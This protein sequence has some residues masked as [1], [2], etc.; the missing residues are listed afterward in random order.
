[1]SSPTFESLRH[2][3]A[4]IRRRRSRLHIA[5][6]SSIA[7][8]GLILLIFS[9]SLIDAWLLPS[10]TGA[11]GLFLVLLVG[12]AALLWRFIYVL[13][14]VQSD[15][16]QLAHYV[17]EKIPD[18]EQRLLTSLE[19]SQEE[20]EFGRKGVS[21]QFIK[22]LW[23]DAE[24][25]V[26]QQHEQVEHL[27]SSPAPW[28]AM[29]TA[30]AALA[31]VGALFLSSD[32]LMR[33]G[34][35]LLWP[36]KP[37]P[38]PIA[39]A[40][41]EEPLEIVITVEPG[42]ISMQRGDAATI[43][44]RVLNAAP[45]DVQLRMQTDSVNWQDA[46]MGQDGSGSD[47]ASYSYFLPSVQQDTV[48]YVNFNHLG[49]Q[50]SQQFRIN[51]YDLPKVEQINVAY[52][53]PEYTGWNNERADNSGDM[54]VPEGTKVELEV[55]FNKN[56]A[57]AE[58]EFQN[59][60][61]AY[62]NIELLVDGAAG[63]VA[64]TV[65]ADTAY[66]INAVDFDRL[67][68]RD[69]QDYYIRAIED[70]PP[71]LVLRSPG[72]DQDV[73]P[74][75]EVVLEVE[76][77]DDYGISRFSLHYSVVGADE[78]AVDFLPEK[79]TRTIVGNELI[80]LEDLQ[81]APGD[82]V[83]YYLTLADNN[84]LQGAAEVIS[85]IYFLQIIPT[86]QEFRQVNSGGQGQGRQ[87]G[88]RGD[89]SELVTVQKD[90][91]AATWKLRQQI[92][93][94]ADSF[95]EDVAVVAEA[96]LEATQRAQM[97][98][99][100]LSERLSFS[101]ASYDSA[102]RN[103]QQAIEQMNLAVQELS[104]EQV[105]SAL[106]PE[107]AALQFIL[108]AE[109]DINRT[110]VTMQQANGGGG[111]G[112]A[113]QEREDL[114]ELFDM[115]MG[116]R[117][118]RYETPSSSS[119]GTARNTSEEANKL[120]ELA[121]RQEGLTR[122]Q[123]N[124]SRRM[125]DM[126]E[127][128][129]RR[130]LEKLQREQ[131]KLSDE[132]A[133]LAQQ[134]SRSGQQGAQQQSGQQNSPPK[135]QQ[136]DSAQSQLQRAAEQMQE[137]AEA[138]SPSMAAARSQRALESLR[139]QQRKMNQQQQGNS[140]NQLAQ[141]AAQRGQELIQQQR[142]LQR[143]VQDAS[144]EQGLGQTRQA[145]RNSEQLGDLT[146]AQREQR[147]ELEEIE[148][149]LRAII[150]RGDNEDQRLLSQAQ[151]ANRAIRPIREQMDTSNRVLSNGMVSLSADIEREISAELSALGQLLQALN[152]GSDPSANGD[153][154]MQAARDAA[155]LKEQ[156]EEL[157]R[158]AFALT[159][160]GHQQADGSNASIAD[161]RQRLARSQELAQHLTDQLQQQQ[162]QQQQQ[163]SGRQPSQQGQPGQAGQQ[164]AQARQPGQQGGQGDP[165]QQ[166]GSQPGGDRGGFGLGRIPAPGETVGLGNAR[167]IRSE[168]TRQSIESFLSQPEL[169]T[170]LLQP[171]IELEGQLRAQAELEQISRKLYSAA[172]ENVPDQYRR[173]VQEYY[174]VL[175]DSQSQ[176]T[177][178]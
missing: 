56:V 114:R 146:A 47:S 167:S 156:V 135:N 44:A 18:L 91:I 168:L 92:N 164:Q 178:Q 162:Q 21:L 84:D 73:M 81:V 105:N 15:D 163:Q 106:K 121:R 85:D 108:R 141:N 11:I 77:T 69:P 128:Q 49:E 123:R 125:E 37:D 170:A 55:L 71:T 138:D 173:L 97:S 150:A 12:T 159:Q 10:R 153:P 88:S 122:A 25:H 1:M 68:S 151:Q 16:R 78:V 53:Y 64:F 174:R 144:R 98:I 149:M 41:T 112:G 161:M 99:D 58:I 93:A 70:T 130:E 158:Q 100:R 86:D 90:I 72:R 29:G 46:T 83:S 54:V 24:Q 13:H 60:D 155:E 35:Q 22:Q 5:Q 38:V 117:E 107:Q 51:V 147:R 101:D 39:L 66:R 19:F 113:Q 104:L 169:L 131:E 7:L 36:F 17:E 166:G 89:S 94:G 137:A 175:S 20:L 62:E 80:Y 148:K 103:L 160:Q 95:S 177:A 154:I 40:P 102:V 61:S 165:A 142:E 67:E 45:S 8:I 76:A 31:L 50:R 52:S 43:V 59:P 120:E 74:L 152:P 124:L 143:Q 116:Q 127:E 139:E 33:A 145:A 136:A 133:Q 57:S 172:D 75:E 96:Q 34:G 6:Q 2:T 126:T 119:G 9:L 27:E 87:G 111:G 26:Q 30:V 4:N 23:S 82:F 28:F 63:R 3:L 109:A 171:I 134:L 32:A 110:N 118:N 14:R 132:V 115:E 79:P 129:R 48:Y 157:Q 42:D 65:A 176:T 140:V